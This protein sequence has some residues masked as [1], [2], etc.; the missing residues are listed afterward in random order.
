MKEK[1][2]NHQADHFGEN[3]FFRNNH[4]KIR[5]LITTV[6]F[7][8]VLGMT[9]GT[10]I[11]V[12]NSVKDADPDKIKTAGTVLTIFTII[13]SL[14]F[15][16]YIV[17]VYVDIKQSI[18]SRVHDVTQHLISEYKNAYLV[19]Y[20]ADTFKLIRSDE[21]FKAKYLIRSRFLNEINKYVDNSVYFKD[22]DY[23]K[24]ELDYAVIIGNLIKKGSYSINYREFNGADSI[25]TEMSFSYYNEDIILITIAQKG[26]KILKDKLFNLNEDDYF[27]LF[28]V[29]LDSRIVQTI[30][31]APE[32]SVGDK[33]SSTASYEQLFDNF[34]SKHE[35]ETKEFFDRMKDPAFVKQELLTENKRTFFY[36]SEDSEG[37]SWICVTIYVLFRNADGTPAVFSLGFN[38]MDSFG[39]DHQELQ[40]QLKDALS[41]AES[42]NRAKTIFLSNMSHDIRTPMNAIIGYTGLA[43]NHI[44]NTEQVADYLGK[45]TQASSHLLA[46]INDI[47]DMSRIESGKISLDE[48][49][50]DLREIVHSLIEIIQ[51][52]VQCKQ[53]KFESSLDILENDVVCDK[54][55]LKQALLNVL[56][57][58]AKFTSDLGNITFTVKQLEE[59]GNTAGK[60]EFRV[61]DNGIGMS[62]EY[63]S[64]IFEPFSREKSTTKS[65]VQGTGL[66]M[67]ITK[68]IIDMMHG[69]INVTSTINKGTEV[70]ITIPLQ[71]ADGKKSESAEEVIDYT[72]LDYMGTKVLVVEDNPINREIA[73]DLLHE[74][75]FIIKCA[76]DGDIAVDIMKNAQPG[77]FDVILMDIQMPNMDGYEATR[78]IRALGTEISKIPIIAMTANAFKEDRIAAFES[79]M[80]EHLAKPIQIER[81]LE[82]LAKFTKK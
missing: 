72:K 36:K 13:E 76:E 61:T 42:A 75:G 26:S 80:N 59:I 45:I 68:N 6:M 27:A 73:T 44:D 82:T 55:R 30:K 12:Y 31:S 78:Q 63:L 47:L 57:N 23:V 19:D 71:Y 50:E 62:S 49:P 15:V 38:K 14:A 1:N 56:S 81:L 37:G 64:T 52:N 24:E 35:G 65:G 16:G 46:L 9:V 4:S 22:R 69:Q 8:L 54:L 29:D 51:A 58:A 32:Y 77:D 48:Q 74:Y 33:L 41:M 7:V 53:I 5:M 10:L 25:W 20:A 34:A 3:D 66:G 79:G 70:V 18:D 40:L 67:A 2:I 28:M 43:A 21:P 17:W 39:S 11:F 60:Y